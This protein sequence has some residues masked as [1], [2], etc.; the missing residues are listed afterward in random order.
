M[1]KMN[2][3]ANTTLSAIDSIKLALSQVDLTTQAYTSVM[4]L[5]A[6]EVYDLLVDLEKSYRLVD[7]GPATAFLSD[8]STARY[9][10][11][12]RTEDGWDPYEWRVSIMGHNKFLT[13]VVGSRIFLFALD[14]DHVPYLDAVDFETPPAIPN[15]LM[16]APES[17]KPHGC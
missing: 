5:F 2:T 13:V 6:S 9:Q 16:V 12:V 14:A 8:C 15:M 3:P 4:N 1:I 11:V 10:E 17:L 7:G